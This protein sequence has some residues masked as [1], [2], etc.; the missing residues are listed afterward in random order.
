MWKSPKSHLRRDL[1][2]LSVSETSRLMT[3]QTCIRT[4]TLSTALLVMVV[5]LRAP[6]QEH[7]D[8]RQTSYLKSHYNRT[9][10]PVDSSQKLI[11]LPIPSPRLRCQASLSALERDD[12]KEIKMLTNPRQTKAIEDPFN[13]YRIAVKPLAPASGKLHPPWPMPTFPPS[14]LMAR[15]G[16]TMILTRRSLECRR[17]RIC[18]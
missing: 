15:S 6:D 11:F 18:G 13:R 9:T 17:C 14:F 1:S 10:S 7:I 12:R 2:D 3:L 8:S 5:K 16:L 4:M